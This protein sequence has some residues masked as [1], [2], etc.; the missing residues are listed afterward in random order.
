MEVVMS[1]PSFHVDHIG[2][3][4]RSSKIEGNC[5]IHGCALKVVLIS[6]RDRVHC[7]Y[8]YLSFFR[9]SNERGMNDT[10][11]KVFY[12]PQ[13]ACDFYL[14][15]SNCAHASLATKQRNEKVSHNCSQHLDYA[16]LLLWTTSA[17][18]RKRKTKMFWSY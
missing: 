11:Q 6:L 14:M 17:Q 7:V 4:V 15:V 9:R 1:G 10:T 3:L 13:M 18:C 2:P 5:R 12:W 16:N 8:Q